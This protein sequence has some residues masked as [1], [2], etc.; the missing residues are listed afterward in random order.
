MATV[1]GIDNQLTR[2]NDRI[3]DLVFFNQILEILRGRRLFMACS[4]GC[5]LLFAGANLLPPLLIRRLIQGLTEDSDTRTEL[6][7]ISIGLFLI[8]L[9]RGATRYGYGWFSHQTA[10]NVLHD[11]MIRV[12]RHLQRLPHRFFTD[13][14]TGS[15]ISRSIND[16]ESVEDFVAHGIPDYL[17]FPYRQ[18]KNHIPPYLCNTFRRN[19]SQSSQL[20]K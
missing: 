2:T 8:Y 16:I 11:L 1:G 20:Q 15:L 13:Q 14:R 12:Y 4:V 7:S 6:L 18:C 17:R 19:I 5:G 3:G 10:Y 9:V